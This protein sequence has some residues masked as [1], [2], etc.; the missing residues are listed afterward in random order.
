MMTFTA[1]SLLSA[2]LVQ[3]DLAGK[4][5][6]LDPKVLPAEQP[7]MIGRDARARIEVANRRESEAWAKISTRAEWESYAAA[8]VAALRAS[9]GTPIAV[10]RD[11][12]VRVTRKLDGD[13]HRVENLVY[14]S[15]PGFLVTANLY[16]PVPERPS[17]PGILIIHSHHNP[18][19]QGEL[20]DMGMTWARQGCYV[21]VMDQVG[22]GERR[23]HPF[24]DA[25]SYPTAY[26]VTRQDY[27]FRFNTALQLYLVDESLIGWMAWDVQRG[28][29]LLY[30][31]SGIDKER[32]ILLGSVAGGGDPAG[33]IA[34]VDS[35]IAAV[36]PF[37]FGGPQ[38]ETKFPLP[39]D[40]EMSFNYAG[41]G[42]WES[43]RNI[44]LSARDGFL[45]WVI[46]G[47]VAPRRILHAH[48]FAW[49]RDHDPV[50]KRYEKI[51]GFYNQPDGLA[52]CNGR[53]AVTGQPPE[54][55]HCN[56]I[57]PVHRQGIYP[58][59]Q[60]WFKIAAPE[61]EYQERRPAADLLC[62]TPDLKS[63]PLHQLAKELAGDARPKP[64]KLRSH[65][66]SVLGDTEPQ[67]DPKPTESLP[68]KMGDITV[69]RTSLEVEPGIV[70]PMLLLFPARQT[71]AKA[72]VVIGVSQGGKQEFLKK[73][74]AEVAELLKGGAAVCLPDL[75][76]TG[77]TR[78]GDGRGRGSEATSIAA[79][80]LMLGR[81]LLG[82][83]IRDLRSVL[84][85]LSHREELDGA[86]FALWGDS[87]APPN[88]P[89]RRFDVPYDADR[90][91][92]LSEP[93]GGL[94]ALFC[95]L[96]EPSVN[97]VLIR[98]GLVSYRSLLESPFCYAPFDAIVPGGAKVTDL[99]ETAALLSTRA[100]RFEEMVDGWNRRVSKEEL[101]KTYTPAVL[102]TT[103]TSAAW[104]LK[105][106][107]PR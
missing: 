17:M 103:E 39:D 83:R 87:A 21:L 22:H 47:S 34:A 5:R 36:V 38:P 4:L 80:E 68:R 54:A 102:E 91:P 3:D 69:E 32:I 71:N 23:Q 94:A 82:L 77:E 30:S 97:A 14:E 96:Y 74:S 49:D 56:N 106:L 107:Q 58:A 90:P 48:E 50:W 100:V 40:S 13:G 60:K 29:D 25:T 1:L 41:G 67:A 33:V 11:L 51:F 31:R 57:G 105:S 89:D 73:R 24:V 44:R 52:G 55:T 81:T 92:D 88:A 10:P 93:L 101:T 35:R 86:R 98:G 84:R 85:Y 70:V 8:K 43:T 37:N 18:K 53:G 46:V 79:S 59:L 78:P 61:K 45:P 65:W 95:A 12:N 27:W 16:V 2:L 104:L 72:A 64:D 15:R 26:K 76:G 75:R 7:R 28:V 6:E 66:T 9:L 99:P 42:S 19:T 62:L 20:Q 63:R